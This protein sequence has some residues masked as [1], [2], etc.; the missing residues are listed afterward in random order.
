MLQELT[1]FDNL[2]PGDII[3]IIKPGG[4]HEILEF[5]ARDPKL[6]E[7]TDIWRKYGYFLD[8]WGREKSSGFTLITLA[9][10]M[11]RGTSLGLIMSLSWKRR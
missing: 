7:G 10:M 11:A 5:L 4:S 3:T 6:K 2:K 9:S 1:N 8:S